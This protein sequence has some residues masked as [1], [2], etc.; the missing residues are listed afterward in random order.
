MIQE[1]KIKMK[2]AEDYSLKNK[3]KLIPMAI[4]FHQGEGDASEV[5]RLNDYEENFKKLIGFLRNEIDDTIPIINGE[6]FYINDN[7]KIINSIFHSY[8]KSD[9]K[10]MTVCMKE[11]QTSIGDNLHYDVSA[12]EYMGK[13]VRIL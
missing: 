3:F 5:V 1:L 4:L 8:S 13:N 9:N 12:H 11:N 7:F 2:K 10:F 6:I